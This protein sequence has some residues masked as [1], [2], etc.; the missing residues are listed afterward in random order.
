ME[1]RKFAK[2]ARIN[3]AKAIFWTVAF[4][5]VLLGGLV[6]YTGGEL[7]NYFPEFVKEWFDIES[8]NLQEIPEGA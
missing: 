8:E 1:H 3:R 2:A 6:A 7:A 5:V 4:H